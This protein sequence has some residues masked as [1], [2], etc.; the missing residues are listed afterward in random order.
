VVT[1]LTAGRASGLLG[2][3]FDAPIDR[4]A[5]EL[6]A[7]RAKAGGIRGEAR[8]SLLSRLKALD[9]DLVRV[10]R[11]QIDARDLAAMEREAD[12]DL[13]PF[14]AGMP[15]EAFARA[16]AAAIERLVRARF[17]LPVVSYE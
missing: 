10:A 17:N 5:R 14:R 6:D 1:R 8:S 7:A 9:A 16:R 11:A 13:A 4:A 15:P 3:V 2:E 12:D